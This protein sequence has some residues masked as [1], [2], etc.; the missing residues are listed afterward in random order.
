VGEAVSN[1]DADFVRQEA[2]KQLD[3]GADM[4]DVNGGVAGHEVEYLCWM[5]KVVQEL[6]DIPICLDSA[7]PTALRQALPLCRRTPMIN[8]ITDEPER[9]SALSPLVKEFGTKVIALCLE[10][11]GTPKSADDR[12]A[13]ASRL[14]DQLTESG[15]PLERIYVDPCVFPVSTGPEHGPALIDAIGMIKEDFPEVHI[16]C[17]VSNVSFGLPERRLLNRVFLP[18]LLAK[19]MDAAILD[20]CDSQMMASIAAAEALLGIDE[21]CMSYLEAHR[22]GKLPG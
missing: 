6:G 4:L 7:D 5:V 8:S 14:I 3:A 18:M 15:I 2:Q 10:A 9:I 19:G 16:S 21:F 20:P 12:V 22:K 13:T 11:S 1:G 17:G